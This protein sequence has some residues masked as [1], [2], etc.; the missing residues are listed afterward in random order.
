MTA[1]KKLTTEIHLN[2]RLVEEK[3]EKTRG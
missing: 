2:A 3:E 1:R